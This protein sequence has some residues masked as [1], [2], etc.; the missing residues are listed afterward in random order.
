MAASLKPR[1]SGSTGFTDTSF[2]QSSGSRYSSTPSGDLQVVSPLEQRIRSC[3]CGHPVSPNRGGV[4][5]GRTAASEVTS[6]MQSFQA[7]N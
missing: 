2:H 3:I 6:F 5:P 7:V 4:R 1:T